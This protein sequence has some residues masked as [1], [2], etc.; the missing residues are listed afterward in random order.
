MSADVFW[1][2]GGRDHGTV[3]TPQGSTTVLAVYTS[4]PFPRALE[5]ETIRV[6]SQVPGHPDFVWTCSQAPALDEIERWLQAG[7]LF[8]D[9]PYT[10]TLYVLRDPD[11]N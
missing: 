5:R 2:L 7:R 3:E 9:L 6:L 10:Q 1:L 4:G 8:A 11:A